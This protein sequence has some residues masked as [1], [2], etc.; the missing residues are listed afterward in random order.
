MIEKH[1]FLRETGVFIFIRKVPIFYDFR[2]FR[3]LFALSNSHGHS[4]SRA[5][6]GVV[7]HWEH[8]I[9]VV[10]FGLKSINSELNRYFLEWNLVF[11]VTHFY[12]DI[13]FFFI[14]G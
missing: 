12:Q 14:N 7:A 9:F 1:P 2:A 3:L 4:D 8:Q 10:L 11:V 6:H 13:L 5:D